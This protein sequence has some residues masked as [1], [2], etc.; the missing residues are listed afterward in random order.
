MSGVLR[1]LAAS[2][3]F[4]SLVFQLSLA[5]DMISSSRTLQDGETCV[6][7]GGT[8][9][10]GFFSP[11]TST[12]RYLG[13]WY[14]NIRT[15][16]IIWVANRASP[17]NDS[18]GILM[19]ESRSGNLVIFSK[20]RNVEV[21]SSNISRKVE[22]PVAQ[23][24]D[25]GNLVLRGDDQKLDFV[26]QS[27]DYPTD[28]LVAGMK[29][30]W[31]LRTGINR[32]LTSWKNVNDPAPSDFSGGIE[33][34]AFPELVIR[35][36]QRPITRCGPWNGFRFSG[37]PSLIPSRYYN[38]SFVSNENETY[39]SYN[40]LGIFKIITVLN[41]TNDASATTYAWLE[42]ERYWQ[43]YLALPSDICEHYGRC[44]AYGICS[45]IGYDG[46][47]QCLCFDGFKP[48]YQ[49]QWNTMN[50]SNGCVRI[51][52]FNCSSSDVF[53][54]VTGIKLPD[55]ENS[56]LNKSMS[57]QECR[58]KCLSNCSCTAYANSDIR[59]EGSGCVIWFHDLLD[60]RVL[61]EAGQDIY[62]RMPL[63]K[64]GISMFYLLS[65]EYLFICAQLNLVLLFRARKAL[66]TD[67]K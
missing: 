49:E 21:W 55:T 50:W 28:T 62:L 65:S 13:I 48:R 64:S 67:L 40:V 5:L 7:S 11:G 19:I 20:T 12:N 56:W 16:S 24:L 44:G 42:A 33:H 57:L 46:M 52:P 35:K 41:E 59:S 26:W 36:G 30:G 37:V 53:I 9:E 29:L 27:F 6:S 8:V 31:D 34:S 10:M 61:G 45:T 32:R 2:A 60:V 15:K 58:L 1:F 63:S 39:Y 43:P 14:K 17:V 38:F 54:K 18:S 23:L 47:P 66:S 25:S 3:G 22:N 4:F 51:H